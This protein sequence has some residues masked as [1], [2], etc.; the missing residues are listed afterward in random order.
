[1]AACFFHGLL[2]AS[3][4]LY[5][6]TRAEHHRIELVAPAALGAARQTTNHD[7]HPLSIG[8]WTK[9]PQMDKPNPRCQTDW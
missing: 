1:M 9:L 2:Q 8:A 6:Q 3:H 4:R 5:S 7:I